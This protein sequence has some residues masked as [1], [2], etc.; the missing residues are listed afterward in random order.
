MAAGDI[1]LAYG[2]SS[3]L[4]QTNLDGLASDT[5]YLAGW[6]SDAIDNSSNLYTDYIINA[7]VVTEG[8]GVSAGEIRMYLVAELEDS[9]WPDVFD[10]TESAETITDTEVRDAICRLA[11]FTINDTSTAQTY[12]L[13][14]PSVAAVFNGTVPRKFVVFI[15]Q[16]TGAALETT[17]DPNQVYV[18]GVYSTVAQ[19]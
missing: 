6:E 16:G 2:A 1:K 11:A 10:G 13:Q 5:T 4:T 9:S 17:G 19:S 15:T 14:C 18:K 7:K 12:Y 8:A 3:A